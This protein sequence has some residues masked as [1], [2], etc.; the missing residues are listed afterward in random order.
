MPCSCSK[1]LSMPVAF[2]L[3]PSAISWL[4]AS[5]LLAAHAACMF[6][7]LHLAD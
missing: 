1:L 3:P 2:W 7:N 6:V 4:A 5:R